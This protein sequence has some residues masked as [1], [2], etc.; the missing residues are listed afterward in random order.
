MTTVAF[1]SFEFLLF[2][3]TSATLLAGR[4]GRQQQDQR[5]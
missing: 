1:F 5:G 3:A 2:R 4:A